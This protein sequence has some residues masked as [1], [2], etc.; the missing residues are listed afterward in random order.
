MG[1]A[2]KKR[3]AFLAEH[4]LCCFCGG[5][6][7]ATTI[8]HVPSRACFPR[9]VGPEGYEFPACDACQTSYR[10][11]EQ[12]FAFF[13]RTSDRDSG[14][15]DSETSHRLIGGLKNNLP[16]LFPD[17]RISARMKRRGLREFGLE[18]PSG[19]ALSDIP[20]VAYPA[21]CD[22]VVRAVAMKIALALYY[23]HKGRAA[24]ADH[25]LGAFWVQIA[26]Q[27]VMAD[28]VK[29]AHDLGAVTVGNRTNTDLDNLFRY[30]WSTEEPGHPD[31]FMAIAQFGEGVAL[32][33][34]LCADECWTDEDG[35]GHWAKVSC[36][37]SSS[38][39]GFS[40]AML[41]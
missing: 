14:N 16:H 11:A 34:I 30:R 26:N 20:M 9:R 41:K 1:A 4:P 15:Y 24:P 19:Q 13:V 21:E 29:V 36:W 32:C 28:W 3:Q 39:P 17:P 38:L 23:K 33:L 5:S 6:T 10:L 2:R 8:D 7:P 12:F 37:A 22:V 18:K 27:K 25:W 40:E 31:I 35:L